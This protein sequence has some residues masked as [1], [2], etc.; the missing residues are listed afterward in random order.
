MMLVGQ[1][2]A[3]CDT[4]MMMPMATWRLKHVGRATLKGKVVEDVHRQTQECRRGEPL[5]GRAGSAG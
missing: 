3:T 5:K 2:N 1:A 4:L